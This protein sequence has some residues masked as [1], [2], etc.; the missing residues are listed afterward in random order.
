MI[1]KLQE[2]AVIDKHVMD[3][4]KT[5]MSDPCETGSIVVA[6]ET[7]APSAPTFSIAAEPG[8]LVL[9]LTRPTTK[10][11]GTA[12]TSFREFAIYHSSSGTTGSGIDISDDGTYDGIIYSSATS[13]EHK[14]TVE[15]FFRVTALNT[16]SV[17]SLPSAEDSETP[18]GAAAP[19]ADITADA[20]GLV[21]DGN[22]I[23][24]DGIIGL[25]FLDPNS[26]WSLFSHW[27]IQFALST[28]SGSSFGA[29]TALTKTTKFGYLHKGISIAAGRRY[30]YQGRPVGEDGTASTT[31][32]ESDNSGDG[33]PSAG[34]WG[35]DNDDLVAETVLA[36][37]IIALNEVRAEHIDTTT[38]SAIS[39]DLGTVTAGTI[40]ATVSVNA[41]AIDAG[42]LN[43]AA[44]SRSSLSIIAAEIGS[45]AVTY[46][47]IASNAVRTG[48]LYVDGSVLFYN[49]AVYHNITGCD[50]ITKDVSAHQWLDIGNGFWEASATNYINLNSSGD[51]LIYSGSDLRLDSADDLI[52]QVNTSAVL[53]ISD[54]VASDS[55]TFKIG[56]EGYI[57]C[58]VGGTTLYLAFREEA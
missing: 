14:C 38:L 51:V 37:N 44:I 23:I 12:L 55:K 21:F 29:W 3:I 27:E 11:D 18:S 56:H 13:V 46:G 36:E 50:Y 40:N 8:A 49:A 53:S 5:G 20:T 34:T 41:A 57:A 43:F 48:E 22:P 6:S 31:W 2:L 17:E 4:A 24:G 15:T 26:G 10:T 33:W 58:D 42:T 30:K 52:I 45:G 39:A 25:L 16:F 9:T 7:L 28:D 19:S 54:I 35:S 32:D 1:I 47:K